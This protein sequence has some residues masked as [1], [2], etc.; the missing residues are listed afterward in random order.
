MTDTNNSRDLPV[1]IDAEID[2]DWMSQA[3]GR[4]GE[5]VSMTRASIGTGQVGENVRYEL[6]WSGD[7]EPGG[8]ARPD[9]VV[10][11]FPSLDELSRQTAQATGAYVQEVGFYRDLQPLVT[12]PTPHLFHLGDDLEANR[13]V[14]LMG[15]IREADQGDQIEGCSIAEARM[16]VEALGGLHGPLW[17][18]DLPGEYHWISA[19]DG[20]RATGHA[21]LVSMLAP[22][23]RERYEGRLA[24]EVLR[25]ADWVVEHFYA[26]ATSFETPTTLVHGDYRL[27]NLLFGRPGSESAPLTVVDWQTAAGGHG[28]A[29]AAYFVGA[30]LLPAARREHEPELIE[31]YYQALIDNGVE[32]ERDVVERDYIR[33]SVSGLSMAMIASQIVGQTERGDEMFCVMAERHAAQMS[34]LE[35]GDLY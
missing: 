33:G 7:P 27:D 6:T 10:G 34:D 9:S 31:L 35:I 4:P 29:D 21:D 15:D 2:E 25:A 3:L 20:E 13:F 11:K 24:P 8:S 30:G 28:P 23:F 12:I 18:R 14:L 26:W 17:G 32:I 5:I 19:R 22:G 16:A 1:L